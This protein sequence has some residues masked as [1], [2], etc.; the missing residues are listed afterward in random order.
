MAPLSGD[1]IQ[2]V[3]VAPTFEGTQFSLFQC[4]GE[5]KSANAIKYGI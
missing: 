4:V 1:G 3:A 2:I 5:E